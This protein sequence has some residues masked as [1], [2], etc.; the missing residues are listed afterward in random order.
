MGWLRTGQLLIFVPKEPS[1]P[2]LQIR[3]TKEMAEAGMSIVGLLERLT[4]G[5]VK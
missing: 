1:V 4:T 3:F 2:V 5:P